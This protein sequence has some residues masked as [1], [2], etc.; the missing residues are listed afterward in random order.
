MFLILFEQKKEG[1]VRYDMQSSVDRKINVFYF[2]LFEI[3]HST[4]SCS[5]IS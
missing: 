5:D 1:I 3:D 4:F 2:A